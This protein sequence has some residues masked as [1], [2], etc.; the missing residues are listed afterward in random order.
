MRVINVD[1]AEPASSKS[2]KNQ[3]AA[4]QKRNAV[5]AAKHQNAVRK[6]QRL[7]RSVNLGPDTDSQTDHDEFD[8]P[9]HRADSRSKR[10]FQVHQNHNGGDELK[11]VQHSGRRVRANPPA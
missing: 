2:Y 4:D 1:L 11:P 10:P 7:A 3:S 9:L 8:S 5:Y 6:Q